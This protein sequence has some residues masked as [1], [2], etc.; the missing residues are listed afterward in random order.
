[1]VLILGNELPSIEEIYAAAQKS[2]FLNDPHVKR[3][4]EL[5]GDVGLFSKSPE[6]LRS[7]RESLLRDSLK[8]F[9]RHSDFYAELLERLEIDPG[10]AGLEDLAKLAV[11]SDMM[12]GEGYRKF[13]ISDLDEGGVV[14][15]SSGTTNNTP[16]RVYRSHLELAMMTRANTNLFEYVYGGLL[17]EGKGLA[18]FLA[19]KELRN[20]LNFVAFVD[21][22]LQGKRIRLL[23]GMDLVSTTSSGGSQWQKLVPNKTAIM[24]FLKSKEEPKLLFTAPAGVHLLTQQFEGMNALKKALSKLVTGVPPVD[25]GSGGIIVTGGGSKGFTDLPPYDAIV[26]NARKYFKARD[27]EGREVPTPFMDVLGMTETLTALIDR[28]G[29]MN[30]IPHPLQEA[31]LLDPRT[32]EVIEEPGREGVLG[33]YDPLAVSWL[34]VFL[35]GDVMKSVESERYYGREYVYLRRLTKDEGWDLQRACGGTLEELM[36]GRI[37]K[38]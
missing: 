16:V 28:H 32:Y 15:S 38:Q 35:P 19:A 26:E 9:V 24:E 23:Y 27:R 6:Y 11:P 4:W 25:L 37:V 33:I 34:E 13:L 14:F 17:E 1:M 10:S 7:L 2:K 8:F 3:L 29:V 30:K 31:F 20:A 12:R 36:R 21:L 5:S 18:L 22:A